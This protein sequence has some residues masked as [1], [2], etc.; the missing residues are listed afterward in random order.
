M[1]API[2]IYTLEDARAAFETA[3]E[4]G[5]PVWIVSAEDAGGSAGAGWFKALIKEL[6]EEFPAVQFTA[7]LHCGDQEGRVLAALRDDIKDICFTG[8]E[9]TLDSLYKIARKDYA[10]LIRTEIPDAL[11][12]RHAE[13]VRQACRDWLDKGPDIT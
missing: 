6:A 8:P 7:T 9:E 5:A 1:T 4:W 2:V 11:D 13:D 10:A 12:L 3:A